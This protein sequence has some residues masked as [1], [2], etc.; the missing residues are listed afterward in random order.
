M[1]PSGGTLAFP[2]TSHDQRFLQSA[3]ADSIDRTAAIH[4]CSRPHPH[5]WGAY[6]GCHHG[7]RDRPRS[8][9][10]T[11]PDDA[12][13]RIR[14]ILAVNHGTGRFSACSHEPTYQQRR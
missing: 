7:P 5:T 14:N 2:A 10:Y 3:S 13:G 12:P 8:Q 1:G 11:G 6:A 4:R 9:Y